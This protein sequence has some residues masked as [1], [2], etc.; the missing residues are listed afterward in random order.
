[1]FDYV[2]HIFLLYVD[3]RR[4][5]VSTKLVPNTVV[6][7]ALQRTR[8]TCSV[9]GGNAADKTP[10]VSIAQENKNERNTPTSSFRHIFLGEKRENNYKQNVTA[11]RIFKETF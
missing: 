10:R 4:P 9:W 5:D 2:L 8:L 11:L 6:W 3:L 1:M 7:G